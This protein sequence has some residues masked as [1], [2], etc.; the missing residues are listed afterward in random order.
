MEYDPRQSVQ[1]IHEI[2]LARQ[3]AVRPGRSMLVTVRSASALTVVGTPRQ[4]DENAVADRHQEYVER[5]GDSS[6]LSKETENAPGLVLR[7][8]NTSGPR[9]LFMLEADAWSTFPNPSCSHERWCGHMPRPRILFRPDGEEPAGKVGELLRGAPEHPTA[10]NSNFEFSARASWWQKYRGM[11]ENTTDEPL[12]QRA[13]GLPSELGPFLLRSMSSSGSSLPR[14][15]HPTIPNSYSQQSY[16]TLRTADWIVNLPEEATTAPGHAPRLAAIESN[17]TENQDIMGNSDREHHRMPGD[18][19][20][21]GNLIPLSTSFRERSPSSRRK[22]GSHV[23][24]LSLT[25]SQMDKLT[26][27]LSSEGEDELFTRGRPRNTAQDTDPLRTTEQNAAPSMRARS[28]AKM[29]PSTTNTRSRA[30]SL[31]PVKSGLIKTPEGQRIRQGIEVGNAS[32]SPSKG[33]GT[34]FNDRHAPTAHGTP[35][36]AAKR[37]VRGHPPPIDTDIAR[38]YARQQAD[39]NPPIIVH[40]PLERNAS[41]VRDPNQPQPWEGSSSSA[42]SQ[43]SG[44]ER[45]PSRISPLRIHKQNEPKHVSILQEYAEKMDKG[46]AGFEKNGA[47][48]EASTGAEATYNPLAPLLPQRPAIRMASK[49]MIGEGGWLENTS[50]PAPTASPTR[51][52][53]FLGN[54]I[55]DAGADNRA[56]RKSRESDKD[57]SSRQPA[58]RGLAISLSPREQSLLYCELEFALATALNDYITAQFNAGRL[59]ADRLKKVAEEWQRKGRPKVVGFR[60]DLE[61]QL[62]LVRMHVY[63]FKFYSRVAATTALLGIIDTMKANAR[64]LRI[65]TFCQPDTVVAKQLLDSQSLFNILGCPEDQQIKLAE[66]FAFFKAAIERERMLAKQ[67]Q[68]QGQEQTAGI[69]TSVAAAAAATSMTM[70]NSRSPRQQGGGGDTNGWWGTTGTTQIHR[71]NSRAAAAAGGM[72]PAAYEQQ[73]E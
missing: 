47:A 56:Q 31:S 64:V 54:L 72:D 8:R 42:Y 43:D 49:T 13:S 34:R 61:T 48:D 14:V 37:A 50:K 7:G 45:H 69:S 25:D 52:G 24:Q 73:N 1:S 21:R 68:L 66:I 26:A 12:H 58:S 15:S 39:I 3:M 59:E 40:R 46:S 17:H 55:S 62:D 63:D 41:P 57:K 53:G 30:R 10:S 33:Q 65:R 35:S 29:G 9:V 22:K 23:L 16:T 28:P 2:G 19:A 71:S 51:A 44:K 60:Y 38:Y 20:I 36:R 67:E 4:K 18:S 5:A 11:A 70:R 6:L 32:K 27:A